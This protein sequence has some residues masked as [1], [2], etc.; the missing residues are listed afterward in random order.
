MKKKKKVQDQAQNLDPSLQALLGI[1]LLKLLSLTDKP[2]TEKQEFLQRFVMLSWVYFFE[3]D[4]KDVPEEDLKK[5]QQMADQKKFDEVQ[6]YLEENFPNLRVALIKN[7]L[8]AKKAIIEEEIEELL[9]KTEDL[10]DKE[11]FENMLKT[12]QAN[13]WQEFIYYL[14]K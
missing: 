12:A 5:L 2:D 4:G 3:T 6:K 9:K 7:S 1:D 14:N 11:K 8:L 13:N 10:N